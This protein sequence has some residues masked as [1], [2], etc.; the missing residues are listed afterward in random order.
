MTIIASTIAANTGGGIY[1]GQFD[2]A[3]LGATIVSGNTGSNCLGYD[4]EAC[5]APATT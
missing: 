1:S 3:T 4:G 2:V 5:P